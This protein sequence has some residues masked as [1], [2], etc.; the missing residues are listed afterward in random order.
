MEHDYKNLL[1]KVYESLSKDVGRGIARIDPETMQ[2]LGLDTGDIIEICGKKSSAAKVMPL[3]PNLRG[4]SLIQID[5]CMR[6]NAG[7]SIGEKVSVKKATYKKAEKISLVNC[8]TSMWYKNEMDA[9]YIGRLVEGL[10]VIKGSKVR[11]NLIGSQINEFR[12]EQVFPEGIVI[13]SPDTKINIITLKN[14]ENKELS[15]TY[16]DIGGLGTELMKIREMI[17]LPLKYPELFEKLGIDAPKG[18]LLHG[19]PGT[20][21]TLIA[22]AVANETNAFF[23]SIN[24]PEIINKYYGESEA[25]LRE[26]FDKAVNNSPSI[27]FIDEIDAIAPRREETKGDVEKRVVAQLLTLMDGIKTRGRVIVIGAT[28]IPNS[29]DPALRRPGRFDR[30]INISIPDTN[31]RLEILNI[32]TRGMPLGPDVNL[33]KIAE[34]TGGFVGADLK[35]LC[36]EAAMNT[37][38][39]IMSRYDLNNQNNLNEVLF[40][41]SIP[42]EYFL[43]A[44]HQVEPSIIRDVIIETPSVTWSE[45]GGMTEIKQRFREI[46][47]WPFIH[48]DI[49]TYANVITP[50]G[51]LLFGPP[52]TGKTLLAKAMANEMGYNFI[53]VNGPSVMSKWVGE[54]EKNLR[55]VFRKAR[56]ASPCII[57]FD[58]IDCIMRERGTGSSSEAGD[59]ILSQMLVEFDGIQELKNVLIVGATNRLELIDPALLRPGRFDIHIEIALPDYDARK[60]IFR[61]HLLNRPVE[62]SLDYDKLASISKD[63]SG[64]DI[65]HICDE[66][67][68]TMVREYIKSGAIHPYPEITASML[69][70]NISKFKRRKQNE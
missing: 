33:R 7:V 45:I 21:K 44:L 9:K 67:A 27:L 57:F 17:E 36:R 64:A 46:I 1:L 38:R 34:H 58:E 62:S 60:E 53:Y 61:I 68:I 2:F 3:Y 6:E 42:M 31:G 14:N 5:G 32:H 55:E 54:S 47:E 66:A 22:K 37:L 65:K 63:L 16:E 56:E 28:N 39:N 4:N 24:G 26:I 8:G 12:V 70:S 52:G 18:V 51:I 30:E 40:N 10:P 41:L 25:K 13:I 59:R 19:A 50:K 11:V 49:Y 43:S 69:E 29:L 35:A 48:K 23:I 15:V 20:G